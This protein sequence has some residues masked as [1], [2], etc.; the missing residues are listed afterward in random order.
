MAILSILHTL[1]A[2]SIFLIVVMLGTASTLIFGAYIQSQYD[3]YDE[4]ARSP[5]GKYDA[6]VSTYSPEARSILT[7]LE[8][9]GKAEPIA[10]S[11][12]TLVTPTFSDYVSITY[13]ARESH[14]GTLLRGR[15]PKK[16]NEIIIS[17]PLFQQ[18]HSQL[19]GTITLKDAS[20]A[21]EE[22]YTIVGIAVNTTRRD[23]KYAIA[24]QRQMATSLSQTWLLDDYDDRLEPYRIQEVLTYARKIWLQH[25]LD[26]ELA[27]RTLQYAP[28]IQYGV[29]CVGA[30]GI[31]LY[32]LSR[33]KALLRDYHILRALGDSRWNAAR[34][35]IIPDIILLL[36][37]IGA[38]GLLGYLIFMW[39]REPFGHML[40]QEWLL[41]PYNAFAN[42]GNTILIISMLAVIVALCII[43]MN[44]VQTRYY[45]HLRSR[46]M[47]WICVGIGLVLT[48]IFTILRQTFIFPWGHLFAMGI[49]GL[50]FSAGA[51]LIATVP[52]LHAT[53]I[54]GSRLAW[55]KVL[56]NTVVFI[57]C[58][59]ASMYTCIA[60]LNLDFM[61]T[62]VN[63]VSRWISIGQLEESSVR[64]LKVKFPNIMNESYQ[65]INPDITNGVPLI[66]SAADKN[67]FIGASHP[68]EPGCEAAMTAQIR[69]AEPDS[70][71]ATL[72]L[73][74]HSEY[75][76]KQDSVYAFVESR[77][78]SPV[79]EQDIKEIS[80]VHVDEL[81]DGEIYPGLVLTVDSEQAKALGIKP[82]MYS[83]LLVPHFEHFT[84]QERIEFRA[85]LLSHAPHSLLTES[86][87][88]D[89]RKTVGEGLSWSFASIVLAFVLLLSV[90][91]LT[92]AD[93]EEVR[94]Y[95][96]IS[97]TRQ[98][99]IYMLGM[100]VILPYASAVI[101]G[102]LFGRLNAMD[103]IPIIRQGTPW[104]NFGWYWTAPLLALVWIIPALALL[105]A[106]KRE[107]QRR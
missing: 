65:F 43:F 51:V 10:Y 63:N 5:F 76:L 86:D 48:I 54:I 26:G 91:G 57:L 89:F 61:Q 25:G 68:G 50:T 13:T 24:V 2:S 8:D 87:Y 32:F 56:T 72:A 102:T 14:I 11:S 90:A 35:V 41:A 99:Y 80:P 53:R 49:G 83:D 22:A 77:D 12:G 21:S 59:H 7:S 16:D 20:G 74:V 62:R 58:F 88:A 45:H 31:I 9:A 95:A 96:Y 52:K 55:F 81:L 98:K 70:P 67:C 38:G 66:I 73:K 42:T 79:K 100:P 84:E 19:G 30:C 78:D 47:W 92:L 37:G 85:A 103:H 15:Y 94:R 46:T 75:H 29:L 107:K 82:S 97:G 105:C 64:D 28:Y 71:A 40:N 69:L 34:T 1:G 36:T 44:K 104:Q 18:L 27:H 17:Q 23:E 4:A 33:K 93:Q 106:Q 6:I 3:A 60:T 39:V 101:F